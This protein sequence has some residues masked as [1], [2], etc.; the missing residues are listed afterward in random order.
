MFRLSTIRGKV[1]FLSALGIAGMIAVTWINSYMGTLTARDMEAGKRSRNVAHDISKI[2]M[3]EYKFM[4]AG[5]SDLLSEYEKLQES[6]TKSISDARLSIADDLIKKYLDE[7]IRLEKDH[8]DVFRSMK[9]N[10][11]SIRSRKESLILNI[12][13]IKQSLAGMITFLQNE[14]VSTEMLVGVG[15]FD[16]AR[17]AL[18]EEVNRY[19]NHFN[20]RLLNL[21]R[22]LLISQE[23]ERYEETKSR[24]LKELSVHSDNVK[25]VLEV[26]RSDHLYDLWKKTESYLPETEQ[27]EAS[28]FS[29]WKSNKE[30]FA[31]LDETASNSEKAGLN[32]VNMVRQR[33]E[34]RDRIIRLLSMVAVGGAVVFL[35][36]LTLLISRAINSTL[37]AVISGLIR[38][39]DQVAT[40]SAEF[41]AVSQILVKGASDQA[42]SLEQTSASLEEMSA[43]TRRNA[44]NAKNTDLLMRDLKGVVEAANRS[45]AELTRSMNEIAETSNETSQIIKTIEE[46]AFQTHLLALNAAIEAA[47]AGGSGSGFA[48]VA[49]EV[50]KLAKRA[51]DAASHTSKLIESVTRKVKEGAALVSETGGAFAEVARTAAGVEKLVAGI[52]ASSEDQADGIEQMNKAVG[53][54]DN[55]TQEN[56]S[57]AQETVTASM[58]L[59]TQAEDLRSFT[60]KLAVLAGVK[61]R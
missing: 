4:N 38:A 44:D 40:A 39:A 52:A 32:I 21:L 8:R 13:N 22:L 14:K 37:K 34:K 60:E 3:V 18:T 12:N 42:A 2:M 1:I 45:V 28:I 19:E 9:E 29:D 24:L 11:L 49:D 20:E 51:S 53:E 41:S 61:T 54:I 23:T 10:V 59:N 31:K 30:L 6:L 55:V 16:A 56:A 47:N 46:I 33:I 50:K 36:L 7:V 48:V 58:E 25:M 17:A 27:L 5:N 26:I 57:Q 43:M 35:A 15:E